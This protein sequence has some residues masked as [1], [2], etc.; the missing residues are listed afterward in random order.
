ME[1]SHSQSSGVIGLTFGATNVVRGLVINRFPS[2]AIALLNSTSNNVIVGNFLGTNQA[3][4]AAAGNGIGILSLGSG[5]TIGGVGPTV[6]NVVS[7]NGQ[8]IVL[9]GSASLCEGNYVGTD[10]SGTVAIGNAN[11]AILVQGTNHRVS[12]NLVANNGTGIFVSGGPGHRLVGKI[13]GTDVTGTLRRANGTGVL[14]TNATGVTIGG[15][16]VA[17]RNLISGNVDGL[18]IGGASTGNLVQGNYVGTDVT[19]LQPLGNTNQGILIQD[20]G[21]TGKV[22]VGGSTRRVAQ[23]HLG[24]PWARCCS[25]TGGNLVQGDYIRSQLSGTG[26]SNW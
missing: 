16:T 9:G 26:P 1:I 3:G 10:V 6:R 7:G 11:Q 12:R 23:R 18:S 4:T 15:V 24:K 2:V 25:S 5:D 8:A 20:A 19:G 13:V 17:E 22:P 21:A 14:L